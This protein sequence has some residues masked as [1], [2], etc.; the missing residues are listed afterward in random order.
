MKNIVKMLGVSGAVVVLSSCAFLEKKP[1]DRKHDGE[2]IVHMKDVK[3]HKEVGTVTIS[4]YVHDG[5]QEGML[6]KP[7]LYN[8]PASATHGMHIHV[9]ASCDDG[10][11]AAG[12]HWDPQNNNKH[13]GPL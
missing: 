4:P 11:Q 10:G 7:H 6:I 2:L 5:K 12:G 1:Y 13:L 3:T 8:L 9:N